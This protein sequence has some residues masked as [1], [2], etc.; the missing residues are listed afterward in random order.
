MYLYFKGTGCRRNH[1]VLLYQEKSGPATLTFPYSAGTIRQKFILYLQ[2]SSLGNSARYCSLNTFMLSKTVVTEQ[3]IWTVSPLLSCCTHISPSNKVKLLFQCE[4]VASL[5]DSQKT[6]PK[7][8]LNLTTH[9]PRPKN[10]LFWNKKC[11]PSHV[12]HSSKL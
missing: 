2:D 8:W 4:D 5:H 3:E 1:K 7:Y 6:K 9:P 10:V 11:S 12:S